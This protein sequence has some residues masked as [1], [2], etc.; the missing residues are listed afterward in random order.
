MYKS[1]AATFDFFAG[2]IPKELGALAEVTYLDL[3]DNH[4]TGQM[5]ELS[6]AWSG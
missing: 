2:S 4:L 1:D 5:S 3:G 6:L